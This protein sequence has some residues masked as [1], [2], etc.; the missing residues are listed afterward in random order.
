M[1]EPDECP[2]C[3]FGQCEIVTVGLTNI[4][5]A[6]YCCAC[7]LRGPAAETEEEALQ[8][9]SDLPRRSS[10][11]EPIEVV[12]S[13]AFNGVALS[14]LILRFYRRLYRLKKEMGQ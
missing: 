3:H 14:D 2:N 11:R 5:S 13:F 6:V 9:W 12:H 4:K 1:R 10:K 8:A 7:E